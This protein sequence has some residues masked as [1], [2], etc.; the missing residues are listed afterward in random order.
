MAGYLVHS[1]VE[2]CYSTSSVN[3][4][5]GAAVG[6][7]AGYI[8]SSSTI[9]NCAALNPNVLGSFGSGDYV[10]RIA[11]LSNTDCTLLNNYAFSGMTIKGNGSNKVI[12]SNADGTDGESK[13]AENIKADNFFEALFNNNTAWQYAE[14]KLPVLKDLD[15]QNDTLPFHIRGSY[16]EGSGIVNEEV[17]DPYLIKTAADLAKLAELVNSDDS[18]TRDNY[19]NKHYML[20]NDIDLSYY[21]SG[22][23]WTPIGENDTKPF[24]GI[25]DGNG[26]VITGLCINRSG[27]SDQ[28]LFGYMNGGTVKNLGVIN[29]SISG[30]V[31][32][33]GITGR[34]YNNSI[35]ENCYVTG[36][37]SGTSNTESA[38]R[39]VG[40]LAG[41]VSASTI[42]KCYIVCDVSSDGRYVGG[43]AGYTSNGTIQNLCC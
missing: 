12:N 1:T 27:A 9:K 21:Q 28:G 30:G 43:I 22:E 11:G 19:N 42:E 13:T 14:G 23:G 8:Y 32:T 33:G 6:G 36:S 2:N 18:D 38:D 41:F 39:Y 15:G 40:G 7:I 34:M 26:N 35:V 16:F 3:G 20:E 5:T 25:F 31:Y 29:V 4:N 24:K 37:I 10:G 17:N